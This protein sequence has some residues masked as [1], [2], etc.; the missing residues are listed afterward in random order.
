MFEDLKNEI[1]EHFEHRLSEALAQLDLQHMPANGAEKDAMIAALMPTIIATYAAH[2][3]LIERACGFL[4]TK[5][6]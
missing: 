4:P 3:Q 5:G 2:I 1:V 6:A